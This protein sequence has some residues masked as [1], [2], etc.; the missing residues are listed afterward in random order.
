MDFFTANDFELLKTHSGK[1]KTPEDNQTYVDLKKIYDKVY[2]WSNLV[3][4]ELFPNGA[5]KITRKPTNQA[6]IFEWYHWAKLYPTQSDLDYKKLAITLSIESGT[7]LVV[8]IDTVGVLEND[9]LRKWYYNFRKNNSIVKEFIFKDLTDWEHLK[10]MT[11]QHIYSILPYFKTLKEELLNLSSSKQPNYWLFQGNPDY[12]DVVHALTN[13]SI[14][15]WKV[16]AHRDKIKNGDKIILWL[17]GSGSGVY[18]LGEVT[19]DVGKIVENEEELSYYKTQYDPNEDRVQIKITHN[20]VKNPILSDHIKENSILSSLKGGNQGTNFSATQE[21]FEELIRIS[22]LET[23]PMNHPLNQILFGCPGSGK[24]Y[25]TKKLAVEI[26]EGRQLEDR[27]EILKLYD[28]YYELKQ[29]RFTTF[30][31]SLGYED[32]IEGIKPKTIDHKVIYE[33]EDGI[34]TKI[35]SKAQDNWLNSQSTKTNHISFENALEKLKDE[36]EEDNNLKFPLKTK[37]S[38]FT[39]LSFNEKNIRFKK[40]SGGSGHTLS[41][42]TMKELFYG[43]RNHTNQGLGIYYPSIIEKLNSYSDD[44]ETAKKLDRYVLIMDEINRGNI[45]SI[46]GELIT[47][48]EDDKRL[49]SK[50]SIEVILPYSK[51]N[52]GVPPNLY[53][54]GTMNTADRSVEA[55]DTALRRRFS[56]TEMKSDP[57]VLLSAHENRGTIPETNIN[58]ISLLETINKRIEL[59]VDKDHQIGHS[60][61]ISVNSLDDLKYTFKNK[62]IPL[63]EEYFYGDF[64]K[65]GLVLG[66]RFVTASAAHENK[67]ILA[68]FK[69]SDDVDFLTDKKIYEFLDIDLMNSSDFISIYQSV[70]VSAN[71]EF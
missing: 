48:I 28:K 3:K 63:L 22:Q 52:F 33:V 26:I 37:G 30:H 38:D 43:E 71:N 46:F 51:E 20:L 25:S 29:I 9:P 7:K 15:S 11:I 31:Q 24:T 57:Q 59:L 10:N 70:T 44:S 49:G 69:G 18:G 53:L 32:F 2:F 39:I 13:S 45:S 42:K 5:V 14:T 68:N 67:K 41:F 40:S 12:Y 66:D 21:Q 1:L 55:L 17:T 6:N 64:G 47:L 56:F 23:T 60:Y 62:I 36:W 35:A 61:F 50:E 4:D 54:I 65:I 27:K 16:A 34:F 19:S 58:L 8:K